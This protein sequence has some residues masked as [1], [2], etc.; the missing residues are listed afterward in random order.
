MADLSI[1]SGVRS[2]FQMWREWRQK[3]AN[4]SRMTHDESAKLVTIDGVRYVLGLEWRLLPPTRSL[5]RTLSLARKERKSQYVLTDMEDIIG[6]CGALPYK[7][8]FAYSAALHLAGRLSQGGLELYAF[9]LPHEQC[10]LVALNESRPI[11]GFDFVGEAAIAREMIDEFLAIQQGQPIRL[12]GNAG[13]LEGEESVTLEDIFAQPVSAARLKRLWAD[14]A[15]KWA[16]GV[17]GVLALAVAGGHYWVEME[18]EQMIAAVQNPLIDPNAQYQ[19]ALVQAWAEVPA[20]GP[21]LLRQWQN[22]MADL[23]LVHAGWRLK[24]VECDAKLCKAQWSRMYGTYADFFKQLP[25]NSQSAQ[26]VQ[27]GDNALQAMVVSH[28]SVAAEAV[29]NPWRNASLPRMDLA[30]RELSSNLQN[31]SLLGQVKVEMSKPTLFGGTQDPQSLN[32]AVMT[33]HWTVQHDASTVD[34]LTVPSYGVPKRLVFQVSPT[35]EKS[36]MTYVFEGQYYAQAIKKLD[37]NLD[38]VAQ[39]P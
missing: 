5:Q 12:V 29:D 11:P 19:K 13:W 1:H 7:W 25:P 6:F 36:G 38:L 26:E 18:R 10:M 2:P 16:A 23:P 20:P 30:L 17:A 14:N 8:T 21:H 15:V 32:T 4:P 35:K 3:T 28:H 34:Y 9:A 39:R 33:G 22:L 27:E 31:F 37:P 24:N